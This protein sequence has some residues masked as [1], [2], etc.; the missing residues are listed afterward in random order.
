[1]RRDELPS[2]KSSATPFI[3]MHSTSSDRPGGFDYRDYG[4]HNREACH[5]QSRILPPLFELC[6]HLLQPGARVLDVGCGNGY[7]AGRFLERGCDVVGIDLSE[8]GIAIARETYPAARFELLAA[9]DR[10]LERLACR[11]FDIV[12]STEVIEHL[13]SPRLYAAGCYFAVRPGGRFIC[14]T[15]YHGYFKN[16][17]LAV[18]NKHDTHTNPLWDGGHIKLWSRR[19]LSRLMTEVGFRNLQFRGAGRV[20]LLWMTMLMSGDR[21]LE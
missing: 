7:T 17:A 6:G 11:P 5:M 3:R 16:L 20:P 21:P 15:P 4:F 14:S 2:D 1:M 13:Y 19:T 8:S 9:D 10:I 12:V 18:L